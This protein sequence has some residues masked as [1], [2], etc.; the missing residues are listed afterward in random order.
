MK[1][2]DCKCLLALVISLV[3][4]FE[5]F[6]SGIYFINI[7]SLQYLFALLFDR[8]IGTQ[9]RI[10][11][12]LPT[13]RMPM[14]MS[15][16]AY[17]EHNFGYTADCDAGDLKRTIEAL[18]SRGSPARKY[19]TDLSPIYRRNRK[20]CTS[21]CWVNNWLLGW[22]C[23]IRSA[24]VFWW[25]TIAAE[26]YLAFQ[27]KVTPKWLLVTYKSKTDQTA[28]KCLNSLARVCY[29]LK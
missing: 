10:Y 17:P 29:F 2:Q 27:V 12:L 18:T 22:S 14:R 4:I 20:G 1:K 28:P 26:G 11:T 15:R 25:F 3:I 23:Q 16:K 13:T 9:T 7:F 8:L 6:H 19:F 21:L 24:F 5:I